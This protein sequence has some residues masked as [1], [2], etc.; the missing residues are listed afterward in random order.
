MNQSISNAMLFNL[1]ITFV[2]VLL[3]FFIGSLSYSKAAKVK[4]KIVEEI[5]KNAELAGSEYT[6][7]DIEIAR[8]AFT[9][10]IDEIEE[11]LKGGNEGKGIG[12]RMTGNEYSKCD[13]TYG[14]KGVLQNHT[15]TY[16]YCVYMID[17]CGTNEDGTPNTKGKD[18]CGIYYHVI[19]YMYFDVPIVGDLVRIPINGETREFVIRNS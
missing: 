17:T 3:A 8:K 15:S 14:E 7:Y 13:S 18:K 9:N 4:N 1:V 19:A 16:E 6:G 2:V 11:W 5:E 12:Y 10:S